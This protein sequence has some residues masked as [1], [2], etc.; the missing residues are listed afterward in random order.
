MRVIKYFI[1][2]SMTDLWKQPLYCCVS[3]FH[4]NNYFLPAHLH[5]ND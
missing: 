5:R 2:L 4:V 1:V 3:H